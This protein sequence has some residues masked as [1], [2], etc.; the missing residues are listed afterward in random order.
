MIS[1]ISTVARTSQRQRYGVLAEPVGGWV[2]GLD[3]LAGFGS[4]GLPWL[5]G[6]AGEVVVEVLIGGSR[7]ANG[8]R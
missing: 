5:A 6:A 7:I 2:A 3:G 8:V 4:A 1:A